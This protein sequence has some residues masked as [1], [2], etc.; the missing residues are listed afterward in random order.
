MPVKISD[1]H[2]AIEILNNENVFIMGESRAYKQDIRPLRIAVLNLMT[3]KKV[4]EI[5]IP[6]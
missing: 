3:I 6:R 4:T 1:N 2:P 5:Q